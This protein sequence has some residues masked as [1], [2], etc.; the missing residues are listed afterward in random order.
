MRPFSK[1]WGKNHTY[2]KCLNCCVS[3]VLVQ[4]KKYIKDCQTD[5][6]LTQ[7]LRVNTMVFMFHICICVSCHI[8]LLTFLHTPI[9]A[10][11]SSFY[12][13]TLHLQCVSRLMGFSRN[14]REVHLPRP[15]P[16]PCRQEMGQK[17]M[18]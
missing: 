6:L 9:N 12:C 1:T 3:C 5:S 4:R 8:N 13:L 7:L 11:L 10:S 16:H 14:L 17:R 15:S 2:P 18:G